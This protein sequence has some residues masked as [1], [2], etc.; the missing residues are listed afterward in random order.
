MKKMNF[1]KR[2]MLLL[3]GSA[4]AL[5]SLFASCNKKDDPDP[6]VPNNNKLELF[7]GNEIGNGS[8]SYEIKAGSYTLKKG[9]YQLKGWVY[10]TEGATL[11]IEPGTVIRGDKK[12]QATL[13]VEPGAKLIAKGNAQNPIVFTSAQA[14]GNRRPGDWGGIVICGRAINNQGKAVIEGGLRTEH[15]GTDNNDNS[16]ILSYVRIEFAG[17]PFAEDQEINGLTLGSVGAGTQIDHVQVSY[18]ND[19][20]FEWFGG[21]VNASHLIAYKGW[22]DDFDTDFGYSGKVQY[23]L[24]IRDSKIADKSWS[25]SFESDNDGK[26]STKSPFTKAVFSNVTLIGPMASDP[27]FQNNE[28]YINGGG[29]NPNNGS[30]T[31]TFLSAMQIRRNSHLSIFNSLAI[32]YPVGIIVEN[33]KGSTTQTA[34]TNGELRVQN[35]FFAGMGIVGTD[36]NKKTSPIY[37][38]DGGATTNPDKEPFSTSFFLN[39]KGNK[40][41]S[42]E[43]LGIETSNWMPK[44]ASPLIGGASFSDSFLHGMAPNNYV[45]AFKNND[46]WTDAWANFDPQNTVY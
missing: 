1:A 38:T 4:V 3:A 16:G 25:N 13:I 22:D 32:G 27:N 23:A 21:C 17:Y 43:E 46:N 5:A 10:L 11:T 35:V 34:A 33:D 7:N 42:I 12:T 14:A 44:A 29:M 8:S 39:G 30:K 28:A 18:S 24:A 41:M 45:G 20:S 36:V 9:S 15:G 26:E 19:D 40:N 31:G 6:D 2:S 37:S